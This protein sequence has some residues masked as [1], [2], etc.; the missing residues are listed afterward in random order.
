MNEQPPT[1]EHPEQRFLREQR[2]LLEDQQRRRNAENE[3]LRRAREERLEAEQRERAERV[4]AEAEGKLRERLRAA[5]MRNPAASE[6]D[7]A[8]AY[9]RLR[10]EALLRE[11][12]EAPAREK[13][14]HLARLPRE[15]LL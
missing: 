13:R 1:N 5:Y 10:E 8:K 6:D 15:S 2:E 7:F 12:A 11:A 3:R 14:A 9:P 4:R